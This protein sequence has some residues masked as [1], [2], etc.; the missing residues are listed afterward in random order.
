MNEAAPG[1]AVVGIKKYPN[2]RYYN[3]AQSC[4]VTLD[5][6]RQMIC[7]GQQVQVTDSKTGQNIT[8]RVLAQIIL[9]ADSLRL[10]T[11]PSDLLH[12]LIQSNETILQEFVDLYFRRAL[13]WFLTSRQV[14]EDQ[15]RQLV[16]L[17]A[18]SVEAP[19]GELPLPMMA[20]LQ[21]LIRT[22]PAAPPPAPITSDS[23]LHERL[24]QL[25]RR[26]EVLQNQLHTT[27]TGRP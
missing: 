26:V 12:K 6:I 2:R 19:G 3:T 25:T 24:D 23:N 9:E 13:D 22:A 27:G 21:P 5:E 15:F 20:A 10:E 16:G 4:H 11:F 8:G 18:Q 14:F 7:T 17:D 1:S